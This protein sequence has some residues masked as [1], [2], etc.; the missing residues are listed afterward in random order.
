M[1]VPPSES[2][3]RLLE[4]AFTLLDRLDQWRLRAVER[5]ELSD[6]RW[7]IRSKRIH[8]KALTQARIPG[9]MERLQTVAKEDVDGVKRATI[10]LPL[11]QITKNA[12]VDFHATVDG[13]DVFRVSRLEGARLQARY[14]TRLA[15]THGLPVDPGLEEIMAAVVGSTY[16]SAPN[17]REKWEKRKKRFTSLS[18]EEAEK[19][20]LEEYIKE[21]L[22]LTD[23]G[24]VR[25]AATLRAK[26][27]REIRQH[28][29]RKRESAAE[30]P[31]WP[32]LT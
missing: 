16:P 23:I 31:C 15:R 28:A 5:I 3:E 8:V 10:I 29:L 12:V 24:E 6:H 21:R 18:P 2:E 30:N 11:S 27:V 9:L 14:I 19:R 20:R 13:R 17:R 1:A 4:I 26:V 7:S 22:E 25:K 32:F